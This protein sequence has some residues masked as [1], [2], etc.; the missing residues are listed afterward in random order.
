M[1]AHELAARAERME[2]DQMDRFYTCP[3]R[4]T[5]VQFFSL[6]SEIDTLME[7]ARLRKEAIALMIGAP[8]QPTE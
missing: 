1:K 7:I 4:L 8:T 3:A 6:E 2:I 5:K